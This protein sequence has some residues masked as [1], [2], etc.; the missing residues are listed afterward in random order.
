[1]K[2]IYLIALLCAIVA[3]GATFLTARGIANSSKAENQNQTQVVVAVTDVTAGTAITADNV[4]TLFQLK[5][6]NANDIF[7]NTATDIQS[8]VGKTVTSTIYAGEQVNFSRFDG[9]G[10]AANGLS[11]E[12]TNGNVAYSMSAESVKGVDGYILPGDTVDIIGVTKEGKSELIM[13]DLYVIRTSTNEANAAA[14]GAAVTTYGTLTFD[15]PES[16]AETLL[17][18]ENSS[19]YTTFKFVLNKKIVEVESTTEEK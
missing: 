8:I 19:K 13:S 4:D 1:M 3:G 7:G 17:E 6:V 18:I 10:D 15:V 5:T 9:K 16:D 12:L 2:K 11:V 14:A